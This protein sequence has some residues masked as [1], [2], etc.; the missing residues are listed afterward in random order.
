MYK[1]LKYSST[2][3]QETNTTFHVVTT[4][5]NLPSLENNQTK[6]KSHGN[7][8]EGSYKGIDISLSLIHI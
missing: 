1:S 7:E 6:K 5:P 3:S 8:H 4:R 2:T